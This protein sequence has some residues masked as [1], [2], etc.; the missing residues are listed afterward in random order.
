M[1]K[2]G[3]YVISVLLMFSLCS[4]A[5]KQGPEQDEPQ[6][7]PEL[8]SIVEPVAGDA[9]DALPSETESEPARFQEPENP[10]ADVG[11]PVSEEERDSPVIHTPAPSAKAESSEPERFEAVASNHRL[12]CVAIE[13]E[14]LR[15]INSLRDEE[16]VNALGIEDDMQFAARIRAAEALESFSHT[17]PG[18]MPYNTAFDEAG[19]SYAGKWHGENLS[20]LCF[21]AGMFDEKE[22]ALEMFKGLKNSPGHYRNMTEKNFVQAGVGVAVIYGDDTVDIASAQMFSS[23]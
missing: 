14:L 19:F 22:I 15:L 10:P 9:E 11:E 18:N 16:A 5:A 23:L 1:K 17:R 21:S 8:E 3:T 2:F 20:S 4:C 7:V 12:D 13:K 6:S